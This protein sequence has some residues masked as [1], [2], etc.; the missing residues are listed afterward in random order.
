MRVVV[1]TS[2]SP[3]HFAFASAIAKEHEV[4]VSYC[5]EKSFDPRG[6]AV[7]VAEE[8]VLRKW[9]LGRDGAELE[10]FGETAFQF[11]RENESK[12][13]I[14]DSGSINSASV[15]EEIRNVGGDAFV[16]FGSSLIK[17]GL[18]KL[19]E[20]RAFNL[21]LGLSPYYRG[22]ATNFWPLVDGTLE[23]IGATIHLLDGGV[24][25]GPIAHQAR[26]LIEVGDTP[27]SI[28]CKAMQVGFEAMIR[29]LSE[30]QRRTLE[31][32]FQSLEGGKVC[33]RRDFGASAVREAEI[34]IEQGLIEEYVRLGGRSIVIV[35]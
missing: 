29:T 10:F 15:L 35:S 24:D 19:I 17:G 34:L 11:Q 14:I 26:P 20:G 3:R 23:Y 1:L 13:R 9:F 12:I 25:A 7:D 18:L 16:V 2:T 28:G 5:E 27:H 6:V 31:F 33:K 22:S 4:I 30:Y 8:A 21:H 32:H